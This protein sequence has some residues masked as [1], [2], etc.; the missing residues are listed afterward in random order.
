[1]KDS[2][3]LGVQWKKGICHNQSFQEIVKENLYSMDIW[4]LTGI[5]E[6]NI[7]AYILDEIS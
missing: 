3:N 6:T 7:G 1:M 2:D 5:F 4:S